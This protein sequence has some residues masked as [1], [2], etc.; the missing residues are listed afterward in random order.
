MNIGVCGTSQSETGITKGLISHY[1]LDE[2]HIGI[3]EYL[4]AEVLLDLEEMVFNC[5]ILIIHTGI[6]NKRLM[7]WLGQ[8]LNKERPN[9]QL[10]YIV[11]GI[12]A[13]PEFYE[14]R[15]CYLLRKEQM[16]EFIGQALDKAMGSVQIDPGILE[17]TSKGHRIYVIQK[18]ILYI[19]RRE[20]E[21]WVVTKEKIYTT[22]ESLR[23]IADRIKKPLIRC[24]AGY[25]VNLATVENISAT[26]IRGFE[27]YQIPLGRTYA[28]EVRREFRQ[29]WK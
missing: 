23:R 26:E 14:V 3:K 18:E 25:I 6:Q 8:Q 28:A 13:T 29:C 16:K 19:E 9:C 5:D 27:G 22:Y 21:V 10:I 20:R 12:E 11:A 1:F 24:H 4:P 2:A 15:H 17:L 7:V